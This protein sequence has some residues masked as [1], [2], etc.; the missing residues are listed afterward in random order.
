[1]NIAALPIEQWEGL[2]VLTVREPWATLIVTGQ[3]DVENRSRAF[4][5]RGPLLIHASGTLTRSYYES[6][7]AWISRYVSR[8]NPRHTVT[9]PTFEAC[10]ANCGKIIGGCEVVYCTQD[11]L[12]RWFDDCGYGIGL[13]GAWKALEPVAFKGQLCL[14]TYRK[15]VAP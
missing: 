6:A 7:C 15:A 12:S 11:S 8:D 13:E 1:M 3:K 14:G 2:R 5:H 4:G 10:K 9:L